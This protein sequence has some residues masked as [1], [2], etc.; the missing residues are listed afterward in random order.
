MSSL[1]MSNTGK[2]A[3]EYALEL[4]KRSWEEDGGRLTALQDSSRKNR[5]VSDVGKRAMEYALEQQKRSWGHAPLP[6][7][8][9]SGSV[10]DAGLYAME[11]VHRRF[12]HSRKPL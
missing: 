10:S 2:R 5:P 3:M 11:Y 8:T 6:T 9:G 1:E 7:A 12:E 4:Q